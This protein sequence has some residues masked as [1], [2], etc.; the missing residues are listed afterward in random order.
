MSKSEQTEPTRY[1]L[2]DAE[3]LQALT[4]NSGV[5]VKTAK[6]IEDHYKIPYTRQAVRKRAQNFEAE[7]EEIVEGVLDKAESALYGLFNCS[8]KRIRLQAVTW[9]LQ[10]KGKERGYSTQLDINLQKTL[11]VE[12]G[13]EPIP[14]D[15]QDEIEI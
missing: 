7:L 11:I 13:D 9:F 15:I 3:F 8:N 1:H 6:W 12:V 10:R 5:F 4:I 2:S 14:D